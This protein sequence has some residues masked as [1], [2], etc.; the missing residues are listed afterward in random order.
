M[1][2]GGAADRTEKRDFLSTSVV[3]C[4]DVL[5][6]ETEPCHPLLLLFS[7]IPQALLLFCI[8]YLINYCIVV[9]GHMMS[10]AV[11]D[12]VLSYVC[13]GVRMHGTC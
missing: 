8:D 7:A 6:C 5:R 11:L 3:F 4:G 9:L 10:L 12:L 1:K 2:P 13:V